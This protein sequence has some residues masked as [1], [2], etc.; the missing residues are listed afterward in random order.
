M[1]K[2]LIVSVG[3]LCGGIESYTVTLGKL[4]EDKGFEVHYALRNGSWLNKYITTH[5]KVVVQFGK[6]IFSDMK[7][8]KNYVEQNNINIIHCN[9]NNGLFISQLIKE[10]DNCRKIG[11]IHGDTIVDQSHKGALISFIYSKLEIWLVKKKCSHCI[12]V[13]KSVKNI[14]I[15]R[16]IKADKIDIIYTGIEPMFYDCLPNYFEKQLNICTVGNLL[17]VKNQI[18]LLEALDI[19]K[20]KYPEI[21]FHCDIYG[22]G[23]DRGFLETYIAAH[24]LSNVTLK[25]YDNKVRNKLNQYSLYI[26]PSQYES[27]GIAI[28]EAMNAGCCVIANAVGGMLE[29]IKMNTGY[30]VD[31]N[32]AKKLADQIY[33]CYKKRDEMKAVATAGKKLC[34]NKFYTDCMANEVVNLYIK[35]IGEVF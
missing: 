21:E 4:L 13:S 30:L 16:G 34:E 19:V 3:K 11:V 31:C 24:D 5:R 18:K 12:A 23:R 33:N 14:L 8:L 15:N 22:E 10:H 9:S 1:L 26:H 28:L 6:H 27:F 2:I 35:I 32:N 25:G 7:V 17:P 29:I 20:K